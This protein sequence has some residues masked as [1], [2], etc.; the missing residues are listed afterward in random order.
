MTPTAL[1]NHLL[2]YLARDLELDC[3][4]ATHHDTGT[5]GIR[6]RTAAGEMLVMVGEAVPAPRETGRAC[7]AG[8]E[9]ELAA[10]PAT[11]E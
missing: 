6:V 1:R 2:A 9:A 11:W 7:T 3:Q 10:G 5:P 4:P 8:E